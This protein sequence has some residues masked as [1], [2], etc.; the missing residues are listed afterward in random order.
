MPSVH[1]GPRSTVHPSEEAKEVC[2]NAFLATQPNEENRE[3]FPGFLDSATTEDEMHTAVLIA[4][5]AQKFHFNLAKLTRHFG[6]EE[7]KGIAEEDIV[8][9]EDL[10]SEEGF[11]KGDFQP[12]YRELLPFRSTLQDVLFAKLYELI[13]W[14]DVKSTTKRN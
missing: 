7:A 8:E 1:S 9:T 4:R 11:S 5:T 10:L 13:T 12:L 6:P 2:L 14:T 3:H